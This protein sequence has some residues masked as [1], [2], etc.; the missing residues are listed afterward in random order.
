MVPAPPLHQGTTLGA[1]RRPVERGRVAVGTPQRRHL[2]ALGAGDRHRGL[3]RPGV[4]PQAPRGPVGQRPR[5]AAAA[6][7][8]AAPTARRLRGRGRPGGGLNV[9]VAGAL[10]TAEVLLGSIAL[11]TVLP[12]LA[13][14][15]VATLTGWLY[16]H[17]H[18]VYP[19]VPAYHFRPAELVWAL[20]AGP[21]IG[22][23]AAGWIRLVAWV[24]YHRVGGRWAAA[25]PLAA[26]AILAVIGLRYPQ[27]FGNGKDMANLAFLGDGTVGL[28][29]VLGVL[30]PLVTAL[31]LESGAS[32]GL[33]TP[34]M[35]AGAVL[36]A[37]LGLAWSHLWPGGATGA[38]GVIGGAAMLA[39]AM[40]A[41]LTGLVLMLEMT[42]SGFGIAVPV[43]A[44]VVTAT[45]V[46][47][48]IDGYS[49]Y[50]G[51]LA[52]HERPARTLGPW[53][54]ESGHGAAP[55]P[56]SPS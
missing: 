10:F 55:P 34:S 50:S 44:A 13:C 9:P 33:L 36:G 32:G 52:P 6:H 3:H 5:R 49:I 35:S 41:P 11:P 25:A 14:S 26:F 30:K 27:L 16:L 48:R 45:V 54:G 19:D 1:R 31:C 29:L 2:G 39:A 38:Y 56:S 23:V 21:L 42:H 28:F 43:L 46:A 53:N 37:G 12:A 40:Q 4:R 15:G 22:L 17:S 24:S 8:R 51:R 20:L 47:R 18:A 7:R